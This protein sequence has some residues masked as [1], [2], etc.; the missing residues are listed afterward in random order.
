MDLYVVRHAPAVPERAD[1]PDEARPLTAEG[2]D[3]FQRAVK[4]MDRFGVRFDRMHHS[5]WLRAVETAELLTRLL[6]DGGETVVEA[7]LAR[8]PDGHLLSALTGERVAVVGHEPW[9]SELVSTLVCGSTRHAPRFDLRKG[10]LVWLRG[11]PRP[12]RMTLRAHLPPA[13]LRRM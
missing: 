1:L 11:D 6:D 9:L 4:G 3:R 13:A 2:R 8:P 10:G 5:P 12:R 7:G